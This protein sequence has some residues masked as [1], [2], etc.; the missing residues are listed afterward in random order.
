MQKGRPIADNEYC[1][2]SSQPAYI[3]LT[4]NKEEIVITKNIY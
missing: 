2:S 3:C 4:H 1:F